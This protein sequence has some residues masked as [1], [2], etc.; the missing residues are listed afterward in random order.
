MQGTEWGIWE[1]LI[2]SGFSAGR[3]LSANSSLRKPEIHKGFT[4]RAIRL[5]FRS[6]I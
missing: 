3:L 6:S 1:P 2:S 5:R 4:L